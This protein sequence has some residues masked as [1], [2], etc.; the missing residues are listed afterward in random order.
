MSESYRGSCLC[1]ALEFEAD[2]FT[3]DVGNCHCSMCRKFHG[4][5][6]ATI[7]G[8]EREKFRWLSGEVS[9]KTY[10]AKNGT[11]RTFC[12]HCGSSL[13]FASP[14]APGDV[15]EV[16]IAAFDGGVSVRPNAPIFVGSAANWV[17]VP[18]DEPQFLEGRSRARVSR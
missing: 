12:R 10:T 3:H 17:S 5:A 2:A 15:V 9:L 14:G 7:A 8:V 1:G 4:A 6:Y 18:A 13:L 16:A 11:V